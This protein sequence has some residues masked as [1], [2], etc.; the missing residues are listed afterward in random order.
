MS[1][2]LQLLQALLFVVDRAAGAGATSPLVKVKPWKFLGPWP[3]GKN[4]LD[5]DPTYTA[6]RGGVFDLYRRAFLVGTEKGH[7]KEAE[8]HGVTPDSHSDGDGADAEDFPNL[9]SELPSG[10]HLTEQFSAAD[11]LRSSE[12]SKS[13]TRT[14][15]KQGRL[16]KLFDSEA[17]AASQS[18][19]G[20]AKNFNDVWARV[21]P[22]NVQ[23]SQLVQQLSSMEV[24]EWQGWAIAKFGPL[25]ENTTYTV[26]CEGVHTFY[27]DGFEQIFPGDMFRTRR[28][29]SAVS[30]ASENKQDGQQHQHHVLYVP[31]KIRGNAGEFRCRV[32]RVVSTEMNKVESF[33]TV[34]VKKALLP[35]LL[36]HAERNTKTQALLD[37]AGA[38][39]EDKET[40]RAAEGSFPTTTLM[41]EHLS[42]AITNHLSAEWLQFR[43]Q[44][45]EN[46]NSCKPDVFEVLPLEG[47][48]GVT[49]TTG[50]Q[51]SFSDLVAPGQ[52]TALPVRF[53]LIG[54]GRKK[55]DLQSPPR[56][57][58]SVGLQLDVFMR[59]LAQPDAGDDRQ[60]GLK[61]NGTED[62][63]NYLKTL[64]FTLSC[65]TARQSFV[66]TFLDHDGTVNRGAAIMPRT[67]QD[68]LLH[69]ATSNQKEAPSGQG[70]GD[71]GR[72]EEEKP[73]YPV[74]LSLHGTGVD[75]RNHADSYKYKPK[76]K[77]VQKAAGVSAPVKKVYNADESKIPFFYGVDGA[78]VVCPTRAGAHNWEYTGLLSAVRALT[79][80]KAIVD[81]KPELHRFARLDLD[82]VVY[83]GH[84]MGGH[85]ALVL[86][87]RVPEP[88]VGL[89]PL[90]AWIKKE[91]YGDSNRFFLLDLQNEFAPP[92]LKAVLETSMLE[93]S[94]EPLLDNVRSS[95]ATAHLG[96][97]R[98]MHKLDVEQETETTTKKVIS[99]RAT[100]RVEKDSIPAVSRVKLRV[101]A[102]DGATPPW[103][104]R[105]LARSLVV[106]ES[107]VPGSFGGGLT[108]HPRVGRSRGPS[109]D[110]EEVPDKEHWWWDTNR[111]NDGGVLNDPRMRQWYKQIFQV[112]AAT[113]TIAD[114]FVTL[115]ESMKSN[116]MIPAENNASSCVA[117]KGGRDSHITGDGD[118][119]CLVDAGNRSSAAEKV[120]LSLKPLTLTAT[121]CASTVGG[122]IQLLEQKA[123]FRTSK[124]FVSERQIV[125]A[126]TEGN[127]QEDALAGTGSGVQGGNMI[128][129]IFRL[130]IQQVD[131][132]SA[133]AVAFPGH[134]NHEKQ[135]D[136]QKKLV[137]SSIE[138][139]FAEQGLESETVTPSVA[140][141]RTTSTA[142]SVPGAGHLRLHVCRVVKLKTQGD[143]RSSSAGDTWEICDP[144][145]LRQ[146][147]W[148][149]GPLRNVFARPFVTVAAEPFLRQSVYLAGLHY[150]AADTRSPVVLDSMHSTIETALDVGGHPHQNIVLVGGPNVNQAAAALWSRHRHLKGLLS[151]TF[152]ERHRFLETRTEIR[153]QE[154]YSFP[155]SR[156]IGLL[157]W[158]PYPIGDPDGR[159]TDAFHRLSEDSTIPV[160]A[161]E[162]M[163]SERKV[164]LICG[165]D[166]EGLR[167]ATRLGQPTIPPMMRAPFTN[168]V[169][170]Y[171]VV[172]AHELRAKGAG[173]ILLA[174]FWNRTNEANFV[175]TD[176]MHEH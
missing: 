132:V 6:A 170:D 42:L 81:G 176:F 91:E 8:H 162:E 77:E 52:A 105:R 31:L 146:A 111:P 24:L 153:F 73:R 70:R 16:R 10:G 113:P 43:F 87:T 49:S 172:D 48:G 14:L 126:T 82:R 115:T 29:S 125:L 11:G 103:Y 157:L 121:N 139:C 160:D 124:I 50:G 53:R 67:H 119:K 2:F 36:H 19:G 26:G 110:Y 71:D 41:G 55:Y 143:S 174:G 79:A 1:F 99:N 159:G 7:E 171:I 151:F 168:Q 20:A 148:Q 166:A 165:T 114:A 175:R 3:V 15:T 154:K 22:R 100:R 163:E 44:P 60:D 123:P 13:T 117:G 122:S 118:E 101:G 164:L 158:F 66:Y 23:W 86:A 40:A 96:D 130:T 129:V 38:T 112:A 108:T 80:L 56:A 64:R 9:F 68:E 45:C 156:S 33:A 167:A 74:L 46:R 61:K 83:S 131:N 32:E 120:L 34:E 88:M 65:R 152:D 12:A 39:S 106:P 75:P 78:W 142:D 30:F 72:L 69:E 173:G 141:L 85:G 27:I 4:E 5:A 145:R 128:R 28:I 137:A 133:F 62:D 54:E 147:R 138:V 150:A 107:G 58:D 51:Y 149:Q 84:S 25:A 127:D 109:I 95:I 93:N 47:A 104:S 97:D 169:P 94:V 35:E 37:G 76:S 161:E 135:S 17:I 63:W 18:T 116:I 21:T 92:E 155:A 98:E 57:C 89:A 134:F 59:V 140:C 102:K 90:G 144:D 136:R